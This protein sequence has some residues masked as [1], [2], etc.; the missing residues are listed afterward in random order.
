MPCFADLTWPLLHSFAAASEMKLQ[1][2]HVLSLPPVGVSSSFH[3][4]IERF[5]LTPINVELRYQG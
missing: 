4:G 2:I 1:A 5:T 3:T